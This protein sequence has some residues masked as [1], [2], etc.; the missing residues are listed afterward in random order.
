MFK[1]F[2]CSI[3]VLLLIIALAETFA[4]ETM[5][6]MPEEVKVAKKEGPK[7]DTLDWYRENFIMW[8]TCHDELLAR[9]GENIKRDKAYYLIVV[10]NGQQ[11]V[12]AM[13][14]IKPGI[15]AY[16]HWMVTDL[17]SGKRSNLLS[18]ESAQVC[19]TA[20]GKHGTVVKIMHTGT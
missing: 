17:V 9:L 14:D 19:V 2:S 5:K 4:S 6:D 11:D 7:E 15:L 20:A 8:E 1:R 10:N 3:L 16:G 12:D 18:L 13:I